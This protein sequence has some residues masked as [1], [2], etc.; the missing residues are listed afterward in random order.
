MRHNG[1]IRRVQITEKGTRLSYENK[2]LVEVARSANKIEIKKAVEEQFGIH[3][4]SVRT[5]NYKGARRLL[6][7]RRVAY[8]RSWKRALVTVKPG[9]RIEVI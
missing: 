3:V 7:N 5:Q 1:I 9:E 2:Y 4:L 6:R 8:E